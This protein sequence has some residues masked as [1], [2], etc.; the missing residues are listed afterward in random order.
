MNVEVG[1][2]TLIVGLQVTRSRSK[3]LLRDYKTIILH[4]K[5]T[6]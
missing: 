1:R 2:A 6:G 3:K 5:L 4:S